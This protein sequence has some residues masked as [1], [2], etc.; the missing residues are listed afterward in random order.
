MS[1]LFLQ[2]P[3]KLDGLEGGTQLWDYCHRWV[4]G[5]LE[6]R[7]AGPCTQS[8]RQEDQLTSCPSCPSR[9]FLSLLKGFRDT[10][11]CDAMTM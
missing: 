8:V 9:L 7:G 2:L 10:W 4:S 1:V 11:E 3:V 5:D 6:K